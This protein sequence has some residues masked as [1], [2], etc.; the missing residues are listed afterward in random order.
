MAES[1]QGYAETFY[2][3]NLRTISRSHYQVMQI[4][5]YVCGNKYLINNRLQQYP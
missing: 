3:N 4:M 5:Q 2:D 1:S